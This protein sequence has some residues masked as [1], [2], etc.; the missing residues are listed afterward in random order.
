MR[1]RVGF[2]V[3]LVMLI[4]AAARLDSVGSHPGSG[5]S[6]DHY[7][8][9]RGGCG[10]AVAVRS[11]R[12]TSISAGR[13]TVFTHR[14]TGAQSDSG[15]D[16]VE[17]D[18]TGDTLSLY[19]QW[20]KDVNPHLRLWGPM[21]GI[22]RQTQKRLWRFHRLQ[23]QDRHEIFES[24][25]DV[26]TQGANTRINDITLTRLYETPDS[27]SWRQTWEFIKNT[28]SRDTVAVARTLVMRR[29]RPYFVVRYDFTWLGSSVD[30]VRVIWSNHPRTG[31]GGSR[32]DVGFAP[33]E[34]IVTRQRA[35]AASDL[36]Y[37]AAMVD[38]GNPL[39]V[40]SDTLPGGA[41]SYMSPELKIDFGSG[42]AEFAAAF[43]CFNPKREIVPNEFAWMDSTGEGLVT[44]DFDS[45]TIALDST[46]VLDSGFRVFLVRTPVLAFA[47]GETKTLEYAVGRASLA[48]DGLALLFPDVVWSDGT[49]SRYS[50]PP[51]R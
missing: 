40:G 37:L 39:A 50:V 43:V 48:K 3:F 10:S 36:G 42:R 23:L 22:N 11:D 41:P 20:V 13:D 28:G 27:V 45:P 35:F 34:G 30:S 16:F 32:H 19:V 4:L 25:A 29:G 8:G 31:V 26:T 51:R 2:V 12:G 1:R 47:P 24:A 9:P 49:E 21:T 33:G 17:V 5:R 46:R 15:Y 38:L 18:R 6:A 44:L 7:A 14:Y